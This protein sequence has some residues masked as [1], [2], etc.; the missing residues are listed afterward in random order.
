MIAR[1]ALAHYVAWALPALG[2]G[3]DDRC[4]QHPNIGFDLSVLDIYASLC[5]GAALAPFAGA[6]DR[7]V[8]AR[9]VQRHGL[10][11]WISVPSVIDL[12]AKAGQVT[13][14]HLGSLRLLFFCGEPLL[15]RH[16]E[17]IFAALPEVSVINAYGPTEATV[18]CTELRLAADSYREA[19]GDS[20]A[21][22]DAI[23][24]MSLDLVGGDRREEGEIM[25]S[26]PQ[27]ARGY[28]RNETLTAESFRPVP[29][30]DTVGYFTGDWARVRDGHLYFQERMDR[31]VKIHGY[32]LELAEVDAALE[33]LGVPAAFTVLAEGRLVSFVEAGGQDGPATL[34]RSLAA[35]LPAYAMPAEI[36]VLSALPRNA[37]GKIDGQRLKG[38]VAGDRG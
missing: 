37:N 2:I 26:G 7:L 13:A 5:S 4:S 16:L 8:P 25:L 19:C 23:P 17:A 3:A 12:M 32:R 33:R 6:D 24:G 34:R 22:G 38:M 20:V 36:R 31:Q 15:P 11:V 29:G 10:T 30:T 35:W 28:W 9:A 18:S 14:G 27:L 1:Q 21:L